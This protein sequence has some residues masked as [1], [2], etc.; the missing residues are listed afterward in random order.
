ML[1][2]WSKLDEK[3]SQKTQATE[4]VFGN[5]EQGRLLR[6]LEIASLLSANQTVDIENFL[7]GMRMR[8]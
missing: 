3:K 5:G 7:Q 2:Y 1:K 6:H 8:W 4:A